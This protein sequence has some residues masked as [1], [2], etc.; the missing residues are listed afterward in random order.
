MRLF[1]NLG[2][3]QVSVYNK[4]LSN[5][6]RE[7]CKTDGARLTAMSIGS[8][9]SLGD[10]WSTETSNGTSS[11]Q[12]SPK[13]SIHQSPESNRLC[14]LPW[15][16]NKG[17]EHIH[18]L[19]TATT[20]RKSLSFG[21]A[22][23]QVLTRTLSDDPKVDRRMLSWTNKQQESTTYPGSMQPQ[24]TEK[25]Q[26]TPKKEISAVDSAL[27]ALRASFDPQRCR[28]TNRRVD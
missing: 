16:T 8:G 5:S 4:L 26:S 15:Q 13:R 2:V 22:E 7:C 19:H 20:V 9:H 12:C 6:D 28:R 27:K 3:R 11:L 10:N 18:D 24:L 21:L 23:K 1:A 14:V 17:S 25:Q